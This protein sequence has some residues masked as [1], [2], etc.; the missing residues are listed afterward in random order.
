MHG[1]YSRTFCVIL[2]SRS[3][4]YYWPLQSNV[5][6]DWLTDCLAMQECKYGRHTT[7]SNWSIGVLIPVSVVSVCLYLPP[8]HLRLS[9]KRMRRIGSIVRSNINPFRSLSGF[10]STVLA[11]VSRSSDLVISRFKS[12]EFKL[13]WK[14]C[15]SNQNATL[16]IFAN[17]LRVWVI[18]SRNV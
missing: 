14:K 8:F 6:T 1:A 4:K 11:V 9:D 2:L 17:Q 13:L 18:Y 3:R 16:S 12:K 7:P 10:A 5:N 15:K